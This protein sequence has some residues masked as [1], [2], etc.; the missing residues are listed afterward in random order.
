VTL[1]RVSQSSCDKFSARLDG[2]QQIPLAI[3]ELLGL[4]GVDKASEVH[5]AF[6][7]GLFPD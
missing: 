7:E 4:K 2:P 6:S 1:Q 3:P 5:L